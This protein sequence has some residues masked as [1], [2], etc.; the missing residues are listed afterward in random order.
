MSC[1]II[2][3][4]GSSAGDCCLLAVRFVRLKQFHLDWEHKSRTPVL[5][6]RN[7]I[8]LSPAILYYSFADNQA[9]SNAIYVHVL[10]ALRLAEHVE[11]LINLLIGQAATRV[12]HVHD[13]LL[14]VPVVGHF[15]KNLALWS[16]FKGVFDQVNEDLLQSDLVPHH[17]I[18]EKGATSAFEFG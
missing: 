9:H 7:Y 17:L 6:R 18:W 10:R 8:D 13:Q 5:P 16:E 1:W 11:Q 3:V 12:H 14:L 4:R 2:N 15:D